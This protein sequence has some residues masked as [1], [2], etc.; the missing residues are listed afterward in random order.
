MERLEVAVDREVMSALRRE[1]AAQ[2]VSVAEL[3]REALSSYLDLSHVSAWETDDD[4]DEVAEEEGEDEDEWA[5]LER[6][7]RALPDDDYE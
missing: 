7:L 4:L 3:V 2:S 1:A 6:E 5:G